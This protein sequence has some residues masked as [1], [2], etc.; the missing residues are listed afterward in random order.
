MRKSPWTALALVLA[1]SGCNA[2]GSS[3]PANS[4]QP[5]SGALFAPNGTRSIAGTSGTVVLFHE[6]KTECDTDQQ[7]TD[8][9]GPKN[10]PAFIDAAQDPILF[11]GQANPPMQHVHTFW[12]NLA[13]NPNVD[14]A[15]LLASPSTCNMVGGHQA[16]WIPQASIDGAPVHPKSIV[17]YYKM[18]PDGFAAHVTPFANGNRIL[19]GKS[20]QTEADF[21]QIGNWTCGNLPRTSDVPDACPP[22]TDLVVRLNGPHCMA[23]VTQ[24]D[25]ATHRSHIVY[26]S[27]TTHACPADHPIAVPMPVWKISY[28]VNGNNLK[29]RLRFSAMN[30]DGSVGPAGRAWSFHADEIFAF[31][32][33]R[34][35]YLVDYCI[36]GGRQCQHTGDGPHLTR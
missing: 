2:A 20:T 3:A 15:T 24:T 16:W 4:D 34:F 30:P 35:A 21:A 17:V 7:D 11:A 18:G 6:F 27:A 5:A 33:A 23:D 32:A 19:A 29:N 22:G 1:L 10:E 25:S 12:G 8:R 28:A 9:D 31:D 13:V 14:A 26:S 36:N